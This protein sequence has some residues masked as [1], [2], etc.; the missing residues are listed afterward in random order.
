MLPGPLDGVL[1]ESINGVEAFVERRMCVHPGLG[2]GIRSR[3]P[4]EPPA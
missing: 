2:S 1:K 4:G 3:K